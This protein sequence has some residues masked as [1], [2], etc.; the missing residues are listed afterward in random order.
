MKNYLINERDGMELAYI[1]TQR[2]KMGTSNKVGLPID[3]E[4][5]P[6]ILEVSAFYISKTTV[7]NGEFARFVEETDYVTDAEKIDS[8][9]VFAGLV[10]NNIKEKLNYA[11]TAMDWWLD[12]QGA[13]WRQPEGPGSTILNRKNHPVVHITW[14]DAVAYCEWAGG[15]LP[16]EAE[17]E[18]AAR[19]AGKDLEYPWGNELTTNNVYHANTW[20]GD[21]PNEN[22]KKDGY[23]GTAPV[24]K[25]Y[26]NE[27]GI[28]QMIGNVWEW[29][30]NPAR[31]PLKEFREK[32]SIDFLE[33]NYNNTA[34]SYAVRGGSF[35]CHHSYCNRYRVAARN[36]NTPL[37]SA[38]NMGFRYVLDRPQGIEL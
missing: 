23:F 27:Y 8:S 33:S 29:C 6:E 30:L 10:N 9:F 17:W 31:I 19:G 14:N 22:T 3:Q 2:Y 1:D 28:Y 32:S 26:K 7:T 38:S 35:L 16:T 13:N 4:G 18:L 5:P 34:E 37:S 24:D 20:Q 36:G 25:F 21:F 11:M 12:I 15:R